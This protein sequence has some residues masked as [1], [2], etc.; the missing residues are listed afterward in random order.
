MGGTCSTYK[1]R[2]SAYKM[3]VEKT[4]GKI[5]LSRPRRKWE[6]TIKIDLQ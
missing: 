1:E 6:N 5:T 3:L 2:R 4:K